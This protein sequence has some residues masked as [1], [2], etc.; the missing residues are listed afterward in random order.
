MP[1][2]SLRPLDRLDRLT[3]RPW[4]S[5]LMLLLLQLK[6]MWGIWQYRDLA[7]GDESGY[8]NRAF[9]WFKDLSVDIVWSPLYTAFLGTLMHLSP[10]AYFVTILHRLIIVLALDLMIL[11]LM[12]RLLPHRIAWLIAAWWAILPIN[13]DTAY[14]V[15]LFAVIPVHAAWLLVLPRPR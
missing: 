12:R 14:A 7:P 5:Y 13:F 3:G 1:R 9:L 15:H 11:A 2:P 6:V 8:Y 4:F 10:H